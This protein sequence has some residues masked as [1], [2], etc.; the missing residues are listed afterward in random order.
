MSCNRCQSSPCCCQVPYQLP[1]PMGPQGVTGPQG[2]PG[3][4]GPPGPPGPV[5]TPAYGQAFKQTNQVLGISP[6]ITLDGI[7][8]GVNATIVNGSVPNSALRISVAGDYQ[9]DW[10]ITFLI[11]TPT[12][13]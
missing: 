9:L 5:P 3:L 11:P 4:P 7:N 8:T 6:V 10:I 12:P 2:N 13:S 1:G